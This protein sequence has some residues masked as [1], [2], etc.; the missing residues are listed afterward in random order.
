MDER[1][2]AFLDEL[3]GLC[4]RHGI[5]ISHEDCQGGFILHPLDPDD[6]EWMA[7]AHT[8]PF[9]KDNADKET[10]GLGW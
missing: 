8:E 5:S 4:R 1:Y 9:E 2:T 3:A 10:G 6:L 7:A